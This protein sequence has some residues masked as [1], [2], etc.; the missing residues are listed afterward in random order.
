MRAVG[1]EC[2]IFVNYSAKSLRETQQGHR[3]QLA[4]IFDMEGGLVRRSR[5]VVLVVVFVVLTLPVAFWTTSAQ[6]HYL[7]SPPSLDASGNVT[8]RE[9]S[10]YDAAIDHASYQWDRLSGGPAI[11]EAAQGSG[12]AALVIYDYDDPN[13]TTAGY[14]SSNSQGAD[15]IF[16]NDEHMLRRFANQPPWTVYFWRRVLT[17]HEFGHAVNL[18][19]PPTS[20]PDLAE[21]SIMWWNVQDHVKAGGTD[22][23]GSHDILDYNNRW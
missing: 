17:T 5:L 12:V 23:P 7:N 20:R 14:W 16:L 11:Y 19:H 10:K 1:V 2:N 6:A 15:F 21:S 18:A 22:R 4:S 9:Y 13:T 3:I 8:W